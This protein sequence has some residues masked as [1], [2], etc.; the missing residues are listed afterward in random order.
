MP[1]VWL[2][3]GSFDDEGLE[4]AKKNFK[5]AVGGEGGRGDEGWCILM[6]GEDGLAAAGVEW[7]SQKL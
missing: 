1:A 2:Q 5:T 6:D 3:P 4:Y 7:T